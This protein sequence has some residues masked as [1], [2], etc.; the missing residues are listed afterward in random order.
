MSRSHNYAEWRS[1]TRH[2][3]NHYHYMCL[4]NWP[5]FFGDNSG[6]GRVLHRSQKEKTLQIA[7]VRLDR[8]MPFLSPKKV[9]KHWRNNFNNPCC[10]ISPTF[11]LQIVQSVAA[12]SAKS[13]IYTWFSLS[14][15]SNLSLCSCIYV[16]IG[17][18]AFQYFDDGTK[19][20]ISRELKN[21]DAFPIC[22]PTIPM[23]QRKIHI[24]L[25]LIIYLTLYTK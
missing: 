17:H 1:I 9:A 8:Q 4:F 2:F 7:P 16:L 23:H 20:I 11:T 3:N 10:V 15:I 12:D 24:Q 13:S 18:Y 5:I 25:M 14:E 6:L 19:Q 21:V 22:Q